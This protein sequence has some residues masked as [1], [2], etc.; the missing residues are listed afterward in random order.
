MMTEQEIQAA[1]ELIAIGKA[2]RSLIEFTKRCMPDFWPARYRTYIADLLEQVERGE[3]L[4]LAITLFPG[5]GK[6]T[7][8]QAFVAWFLGRDPRRKVIN[9]SNGADLAE[10]NSIASRGCFTS[11]EW[12]FEGEL[13]EK[14]A[15]TRWTT[16]AGGGL[17]AVG[18][19]GK[20]I[21]WRGDL[22]LADDIMDGYGTQSE[23]DGIWKWFQENMTGRLNPN[24]A[25]IVVM[26]RW[27]PDDVV[28]RI[29]E[30]ADAD[31]WTIVRLPAL[32][33]ANDPMSR[34]IGEPLWPEGGWTKEVFE[35]RRTAMGSRAFEC[36]FQ[37]N[38]I[39]SDGNLVKTDWFQNRY[40]KLPHFTK[41]VCGVDAAAKTGVANDW[42]VVATIGITKSE[43]Y[44][45]DIDRRRVEFP[46][47]VRMVISA[48]ERH[49]PSAIYVEDAS[50]ATAM[51]QVLK[52]ESRLPIVPVKAVASK[53]ARIEGVTGMMEAGKVILPDEASWL[54]EFERELFSVPNSKHDDMVDAMVLA[55]TQ[56]IVKSP[57]WSFGFGG[58]G[59]D[60][61]EIDGER[62]VNPDEPLV[63][64]PG[65]GVALNVRYLLGGR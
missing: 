16:T 62:V 8:L 36:Q 29:Q 28:G 6:S 42:S 17:Y 10:R 40:K 24:G 35:R 22:V 49:N 53:I 14:Q 12:P 59:A 46:D 34:E 30:S 25:R 27:G 20:V 18:V 11:P 48:H 23:R 19:D 57:S 45:L 15:M 9:A 2:Q 61:F 3:I 21:G 37:A 47:L 63:P 51:I 50:N 7:L 41:I 1:R 31:A 39:P 13:G 58:A 4:N 38:P 56:Q 32:A 65:G 43:M 33:E 52:S 55:L 60:D 44:V 64:L 5:A 54:V 26:Q